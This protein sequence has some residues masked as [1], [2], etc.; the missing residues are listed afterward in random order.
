MSKTLIKYQK[1]KTVLSAFDLRQL[2]QL[3]K[4]ERSDPSD[5]IAMGNYEK[6]LRRERRFFPEIDD[7]GSLP[8]TCERSPVA[9]KPELNVE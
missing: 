6:S 8:L 1:R 3:L 5:E 9:R 4:I 7:F 2:G